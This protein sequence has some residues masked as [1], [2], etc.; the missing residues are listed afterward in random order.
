MADTPKPEA[1]AAV[2]LVEIKHGLF[3]N[4]AAVS[5]ANCVVEEQWEKTRPG[6]EPTNFKQEKHY[7]LTLTL[8][9]GGTVVL[10]AMADIVAASKI[11]GLPD[12]S[13]WKAPPKPRMGF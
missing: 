6:S 3:I 11:L 1:P 4:P 10:T 7:A 12:C 2:R 9:D 13:T 8:F 5:M